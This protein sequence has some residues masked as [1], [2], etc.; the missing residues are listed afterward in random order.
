MI[1]PEKKKNDTQNFHVSEAYYTIC[2][3]LAEG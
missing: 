3:S 1:V 2:V